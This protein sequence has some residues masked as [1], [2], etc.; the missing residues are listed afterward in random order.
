MPCPNLS[1]NLI[2]L[3]Q[4]ISKLKDTYFVKHVEFLVTAKSLHFLYET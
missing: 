1:K 2:A 4:I 3:L